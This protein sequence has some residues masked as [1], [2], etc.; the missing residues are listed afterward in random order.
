MLKRLG[1]EDRALEGLI[2]GRVVELEAER[3]GITVDD[4]ALLHKLATEFQENG[5][6]LGGK[7]IKRRL[8]LQGVSRRSSST[9]R[10]QPD[11]ARAPRGAGDRRGERHRSR[12]RTGTTGDGTRR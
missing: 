5:Q 6:P 12:G 8:E 7:E 11:P 2:E 9:F 10:A 1:L 4:D 3:L